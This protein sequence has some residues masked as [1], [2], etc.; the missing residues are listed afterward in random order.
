MDAASTLPGVLKAAGVY[1]AMYG[2]NFHS[3]EISPRDQAIMFDEF[4]PPTVDGSRAQV[5]E[6]ELQHDAPY[7]SGQYGGSPANLQDERTA[8]AAI[9]FLQTKAGDLADPFFL[10]VGIYKPHLDW[11]A[12][13]E[14]FDLYDPAEIRAALERSLRDGSIIPGDGEYFD[15][16]PMSGPSSVHARMAGDLDLW[17]DYIHAYLASVSY[18]DSK[19]GDV[20]EALDADPDLAAETAIVLWSDNGQHLGDKDRWGKTTHWREATQAPLIIVDPDEPGGRTAEQI[21]SLVDIF[22]TVLDLIDIEPPRGLDL[23]GNSLVPIVKDVSIDWY[24]PGAGKGVALTTIF[25]SVSLRAVV[26]GEGDFRYTRYPDGTEELYDITNDPDE[27]VNRLDFGTGQ[28]LTRADDRMRDLM[29]DLLQ[30]QLADVGMLISDGSDRVTGSAADEMLVTTNGPGRNVLSGR[31]GDDT[32]IL[33][34]DAT[35]KEAAGGGFDFVIIQNAELENGFRL[36]ANVEMVKVAGSF[37][38]NDDANW[39]FGEQGTLKGLGGDDVIYGGSGARRINGGKG[40]DSLVGGGGDNRLVGGR[41]DDLMNG[42]AGED[43]MIGG[44]G[45]DTMTGGPGS[46]RFVF[47]APSH[48]RRGSPDTIVG[49]NNPGREDGD[50]VDLSSVDADTTVSGDQSFTF[51]GRAIGRVWV[52]ERDGDTQVRA[53]TDSDSAPEIRII[54]EDGRGVASA[55]TEDDIIL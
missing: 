37:T 50:L 44:R 20:L 10:G 47:D 51:G 18:A 46:D 48:S 31:R 35:V 7:N 26:P 27:H 2:K 34:S 22:P 42:E 45:E 29:N 53:N 28:G 5:I 21:V 41:G 39:I 55:Y 1:V 14:F 13:P 15:V 36:P 54:I 19:V 25:G 40:E 9:D 4:R 24:E 6:D 3:H 43:T 32:Y 38:G 16:P 17:A 12:P 8:A 23:R 52:V 30:D 33:Y 49:F 11:W